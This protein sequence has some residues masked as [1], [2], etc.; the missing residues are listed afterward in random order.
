MHGDIGTEYRQILEPLLKDD[1]AGTQA[2]DNSRP[3][4]ILQVFEAQEILIRIEKLSG[5]VNGI[6]S[7]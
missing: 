5:K 4:E 7:T 2:L 6:A 3:R 1:M